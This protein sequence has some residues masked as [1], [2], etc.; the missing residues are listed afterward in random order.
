VV[1]TSAPNAQGWRTH[2]KFPTQNSVLVSRMD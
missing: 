2:L 1:G